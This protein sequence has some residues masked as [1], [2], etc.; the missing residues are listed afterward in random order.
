MVRWAPSDDDSDDDDN[1][2]LTAPAAPAATPPLATPATS[3]DSSSEW[4]D[5]DGPEDSP[6]EGAQS[7]GGSSVSTAAGT[8]AAA[9]MDVDPPLE[10]LGGSE[11]PLLL[12]LLFNDQSFQ[13]MCPSEAAEL[14]QPVRAVLCGKLGKRI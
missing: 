10:K 4:C 5:L 6:D 1:A 13:R 3:F 7:E 12:R 8:L 9:P 14:D 11:A 2:A